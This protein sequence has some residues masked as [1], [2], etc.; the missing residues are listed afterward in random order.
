MDLENN[1]YLTFL[2]HT[3]RTDEYDSVQQGP[4]VTQ[5]AADPM[6]ENGVLSHF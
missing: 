2:Q 1:L 4:F 3:E 5:T 6:I